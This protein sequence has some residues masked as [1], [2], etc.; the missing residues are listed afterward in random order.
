MERRVGFVPRH[1]S[2]LWSL[3]GLVCGCYKH[4][5]PLGLGMVGGKMDRLTD[6]GQ[7][8]VVGGVRPSSAAAMIVSPDAIKFSNATVFSCNAAPGD[9][10]TPRESARSRWGNWWLV[11]C[12][13]YNWSYL[14]S[15]EKLCSLRYFL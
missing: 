2:L 13:T 6:E 7:R 11:Q 9:G 14:N 15:R 3:D 8:R 10:R 12:L 1:M 5:A 4:A